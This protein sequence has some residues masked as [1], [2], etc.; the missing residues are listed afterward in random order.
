MVQGL[1]FKVWGLRPWK[2]ARH[3][4]PLRRLD[5]SRRDEKIVV[6]KVG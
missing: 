1:G 4:V 6:R 3:P 2:R 5:R